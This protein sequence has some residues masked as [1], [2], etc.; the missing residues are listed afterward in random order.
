MRVGLA[1][2]VVVTAATVPGTAWP[3]RVD[4]ADRVVIPRSVHPLAHAGN[5][6]GPTDPAT[7]LE[8]MI[9][10]FRIAPEKQARL[11]AVLVAQH[12]PAS[13]WYRR[14]LSPAEFANLFGP[15]PEEVAEAT[16]WL[17]SHGL[18]IDEVAGSRMWVNFS[19]SVPAVERAFRT[20]MRNYRVG[21]R[22]H[23]A[24]ATDPSI[25]RALTRAVAGVVTLHDFRHR[26]LHAGLTAVSPSYTAGGSHYLSPGDF[27][28]LYD[29]GPLWAA[30]IDGAGQS[31]AVV[32]R[33]RPPPASWTTFRSLMGLQPNPPQVVVNGPDPGDLGASEDVEADLDVEWAGAVARSATVLFV[34]SRGTATTDGIDL[35][36]QYVVDHDLAPVMTTSFGACEAALTSTGTTF[37]RNLWAQA[38]AQGITSVVSSGDSGAAGCEVGGDGFGTGRA[39]NGL[40]STP[41]DVAVGGTQLAEGGATYW[42]AA[43]GAGYTSALRYIPEVAWNESGSVSGGS[44]LWATGGGA[45][46]VHPKPDWQVAPGVPAG[47][48]RFVPDV[49]LSAA[50]HDAYL[51]YTGGML[52]AIAGTSASAPA[53]AGLMALVVQKTGQ[54]QGN[55]NVRLY[56]LASAQWTSGGAAAFHDTTSG[57]NSVPG[58][59]GF[60]AGAGYDPATGLGSVDAAVLVNA[61]S[62]GSPPADVGVG[63]P[64]WGGPH[65]VLAA[66][67]LG[68]LG[69]VLGRP[70]GGAPARRDPE[71]P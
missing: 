14:W 35:S 70:R 46:S 11:E 24:N 66:A 42:S 58:T 51:V 9:L 12:D 2:L 43:N 65:L 45:S 31:I 48:W 28:V 21:G 56:Q 68:L 27:G 38:A 13:H 1:L 3:A 33:T 49:S 19:G 10:A 5:D 25:P 61:W 54:R 67:V 7:P 39:V 34:T 57:N 15:S 52:A 30:G 40:A 4:D 41:Y 22:L 23:H 71:A 17:A 63:A 6:V 69:A 64:A 32:G 44:G 50:K 29:V 8:R 16:A 26:P 20:R 53:F 18:Q 37:Y 59:P 62:E 36:A 55:A 47:S 60:T